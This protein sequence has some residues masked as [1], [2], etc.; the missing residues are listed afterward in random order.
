MRRNIRK[1]WGLILITLLL[2]CMT[3]T[4]QAA[5]KKQKALKAYQNFL[6]NNKSY[7]TVYPGQWSSRNRESWQ[8]CW[9]FLVTKMNNDSIPELVTF[10]PTGYKQGE[11][12]ILTYKNGRVSRVKLV[13]NDAKTVK[14]Y[15]TYGIFGST[16][17]SASSWQGLRGYGCKKNHFHL[18]L[19]NGAGNTEQIY[20]LKNGK[21]RIVAE[22][23]FAMG[24]DRY[25]LNRKRVSAS[26]YKKYVKNC[27]ETISFVDNSAKNRKRYVK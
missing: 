25:W 23:E 20:S 24:K 12:F 10:H 16:Y 14:P 17:T 11:V 19:M 8:K 4:C 6:T 22:H 9:W 18:F 13:K 1:I 15:S 7:Y 26:K 21:A 3:M 5:S 2:T 27:R